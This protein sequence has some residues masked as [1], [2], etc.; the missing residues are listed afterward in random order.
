MAGAWVLYAW[1]AADWDR[2]RL[3]FVTGETGVRIARGLKGL[4]LIAFGLSHF[5]CVTD[6]AALVPS[7]HAIACGLGVFHRRCLAR[8]GRRGTHRRVV[9]DLPELRRGIAVLR[10]AF[11]RADS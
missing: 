9:A 1:F 4:A 8:G 6:T 7:W 5:A 11:Q 3:G 10:Q 2:Q